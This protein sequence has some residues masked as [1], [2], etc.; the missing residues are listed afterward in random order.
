[1]IR[2]FQ[3]NSSKQFQIEIKITFNHAS[4]APLQIFKLI[5]V[6]D[7]TS[8]TCHSIKKFL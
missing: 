5:Q 8:A 3:F 7:T 1:M 4:L 2:I 6:E